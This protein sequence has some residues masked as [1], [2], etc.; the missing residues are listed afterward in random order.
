MKSWTRGNED[1]KP[2]V[3]KLEA[4][5]SAIYTTE[6]IDISQDSILGNHSSM[7]KILTD[8]LKYTVLSKN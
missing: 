4:E 2:I 1:I 6:L 5:V 7:R 8:V 3:Q